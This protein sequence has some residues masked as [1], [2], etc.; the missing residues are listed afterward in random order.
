MKITAIAPGRV[1]LI[2]EHTDYNQGWV[3]PVAIDLKLTVKLTLRPDHLFFA[4]AFGY[5]ERRTFNLEDLQPVQGK[6]DWIDYL[7]AV[8]WALEKNGYKLSGAELSIA[9]EIPIGAGLSS[10]AALELAVAGALNKAFNLRIDPQNLALICQQAENE[11]IGVRCGIMDQYAIV[12]G[13]SGQALFL[14]CLSLDYSFVSFK[15]QQSSLLIVDSRVKRT[16]GASEYNRRREECEEAVELIGSHLE[17]KFN[18]LREI[19]LEDLKKVKDYLPKTLYL[20]SRYI[21]EENAR[22][23]AAAAALKA[24]DLVSFGYLL[25]RSHAG[26]RDLYAVSC[27]ELDLIVDTAS[28]DPGV[29]GARMTGAGFGGCAVILLRQEAVDRVCAGISKAFT[30]YGW[31]CPAYYLTKAADGLTVETE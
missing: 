13:R 8:C 1:N 3:M 23:Q 2:G 29:F 7:K 22:V 10:S 5:K 19:N 17:R 27:P 24:N 28:L 30:E 6:P 15:L 4:T 21:I 11:Y 14:D 31:R 18:S 9:S 25:K 12:L 26:L 20:R 16:L